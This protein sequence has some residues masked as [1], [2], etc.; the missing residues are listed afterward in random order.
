MTLQSALDLVQI[1]ENRIIID[2]SQINLFEY[3]D[4]PIPDWK[5]KVSLAPFAEQKQSYFDIETTGLNP[6]LNE[7]KLIGVIDEK[8][9]VTIFEGRE[10]LIISE[11]FEYAAEEKPLVLVGY[12]NFDFDLPFLQTRAEILDITSPFYVSPHITTHRT[13]QK[14]SNVP[15]QYHE[16][17]INGRQTAIIDLYNQVLAWDFVRRILS[18][19]SLKVAPYEMGLREKDDRIILTFKQMQKIYES[20]D[21]TPLKE[22][23]V[24]DLKDTKLIGGYLIPDLYYQMMFLPE[25][26]LQKI[27]SRGNGR[28]WD[29]LIASE[30]KGEVFVSKIG[31]ELDEETNELVDTLIFT[32]SPLP[33]DSL[34]YEGGYT[35]GKAGLF[36][37]AARGD[38]ASM[39]PNL[40]LTYGICS[41]KDSR[42]VTLAILKYLTAARLEAKEK[43]KKGD[44]IAN[45]FQNTVKVLINSCYGAL[46]TG[47]I[48]YND[49]TAAALVTAYGRAL[50]KYINTLVEKFGGKVIANDTDSVTY[51]SESGDLRN[52]H[53]LIQENLPRGASLAL[54]WVAKAIYI[55]PS[56]DGIEGLRKNYIIFYEDGSYKASGKYRKRDRCNLEKNFQINY[57]KKLIWEGRMVADQYRM[58]IIKAINQ[59]SMPLEEL[60]ITRKARKNEKDVFTR[61]LVDDE[62]VTAYYFVDEVVQMKTK[63]KT[64]HSKGNSGEYSKDYY[65]KLVRD[66]YNEMAPYIRNVM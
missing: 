2:E 65:L 39:Y 66:M 32:N 42:K 18:S 29:D 43:A 58:G 38:L 52:I 57:L 12:N 30:Y 31:T 23:L 28:K 53:A 24:D 15:A 25:W 49:M 63:T 64:V 4:E 59:G 21:L 34:K 19:H 36:F 61:D 56:K 6:M 46:A 3:Y 55:P 48:S 37:N 27:S 51:V 47:K 9:N 45:Q 10:R 41:R 60:T 50:I 14:F 20:G 1:V 54:E 26:T 5:P 33:D 17:Y 62:G 11:F 40:M 7:T 8:D 44:E 13:A 22:Y 35:A 16:F